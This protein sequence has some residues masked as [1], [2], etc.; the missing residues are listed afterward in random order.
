[1]TEDVLQQKEAHEKFLEEIGT[2]TGCA[3]KWYQS[4]LHL[5]NGLTQ[6]CYNTPQHQ[7]DLKQIKLSPKALHNT[8]EKA[9]QRLEMK[10]GQRP[11][12]C[13]YCW[14]VE[15]ESKDSI[16]DR[17]RWNGYL[18]GD[19][20]GTKVKNW[21]ASAMFNPKYLEISFSNLCNF[22]CGYC[23]PRNSSRYL[24]EIKSHGKYQ[25]VSHDC[26][27][28]FLKIYDEDANPYLDAFWKWWPELS[29]ELKT[30]RLTGGEP[31][32]QKSTTRLLRALR[33]DPRPE[34][35]LSINSNLGL[36]HELFIEK[37]D[38]IEGLMQ[39][40][41]VQRIRLFT[42]IDTWGEQA[43][44][45]RHGLD[46][47]VFHKNSVYFL[48][49]FPSL[50]L[51]Y[52]VTMNIFSLPRFTEL[53]Q[54][55]ID[56]KKTFN[57]RRPEFN[58][59]I[60]FDLNLLTEPLLYSYHLLPAEVGS[61]YFDKMLAFA[62]DNYDESNVLGFNSFFL[63]DLE[64][65]RND[66]L[67]NKLSEEEIRKYR[68]EFLKFFNQHDARRKT[69]LRKTFPE[70]QTLISEWEKSAADLKDHISATPESLL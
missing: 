43:E 27:I 65:V 46:L 28:H 19:V 48:E 20:D 31:L 67:A 23:H 42:S 9:Q 30:I 54:Y 17:K 38:Q 36:P 45:I 58:N 49:R 68:A 16:S 47:D 60:R 10:K 11:K 26:D 24:G 4:T 34:I 61:A 15:D 70:F 29:L 14:R 32:I 35:D 25:E 2:Q 44:Y 3:A 51:L 12:A 52:M 59:R 39:N 40:G 66:F 8:I 22:M 63:K 50:E 6:S 21:P 53:M 69:D 13:A 64:K 56:L 7:I 5:Q 1:M 37:C 18:V 33:E 62:H 41:C 57:T 55:W